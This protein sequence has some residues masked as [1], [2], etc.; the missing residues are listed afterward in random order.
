ML[1]GQPKLI[2]SVSR[3]LSGLLFAVLT[4]W[5]CISWSAIPFSLE[6]YLGVDMGLRHMTWKKGYGDNVYKHTACQP[7]LYLGVK[8]NSYFGLEVGYE[9]IIF[10][11]HH[12]VNQLNQP[13]LVLNTLFDPPLVALQSSV[14]LQGWHFNI[15]GLYPLEFLDCVEL[16]G[17]LGVASLKT[18]QQVTFL[19]E[20]AGFFNPPPVATFSKSKVVPRAS[21]GFQYKM[22]DC[23]SFRFILLG[24]EN[25]SLFD[26][27]G[28]PLESPN[29]ALRS[30]MK[31][32][33]YHSVGVVLTY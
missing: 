4:A 19:A 6:P 10:K 21:L 8:L 7:N 28:A 15:V 18:T 20:S 13:T 17:T 5:S 22:T 33:T 12:T 3:I 26:N 25:T 32:N 1:I 24:V 14:K 29:S 30:K 23:V 9:K 2:F 11:K 16:L 27:L 31:H